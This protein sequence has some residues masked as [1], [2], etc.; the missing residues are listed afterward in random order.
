MSEI[1]IDTPCWDERTGE[2]WCHLVAGSIHD[3]HAFAHK[4]GLPSYY[5]Q[6]KKGKN[7]PH[8]DVRNKFIQRAIAAG[9]KKVARK[10]LFLFLKQHYK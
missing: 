8:Y 10:E 7:Q 2:S 6:N 9:A 3:L 4:I 5:F 1:L